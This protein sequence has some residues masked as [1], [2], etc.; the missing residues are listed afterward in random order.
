M[1]YSPLIWGWQCHIS[2]HVGDDRTHDENNHDTRAYDTHRKRRLFEECFYRS[3]IA[4]FHQIPMQ[5]QV[6]CGNTPHNDL[7]VTHTIPS[8]KRDHFS[9][10]SWAHADGCDCR[11][12]R[13]LYVQMYV[14]VNIYTDICNAFECV[15]VHVCSCT[16]RNDFLFILHTST[17]ARHE[18]GSTVCE[19][20]GVQAMLHS[21]RNSTPFHCRSVGVRRC[22]HEVKMIVM[23]M[24]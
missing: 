18:L 24:W 22:L 13:L 17:S 14:N 6:P 12:E 4:F 1:I 16:F 7:S 23:V 8:E 3:T 11:F 21:T 20:Q 5:V 19:S 9:I 10:L 2:Y 15:D